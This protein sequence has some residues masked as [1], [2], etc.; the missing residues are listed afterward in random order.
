MMIGILYQI[1][2]IGTLGEPLIAVSAIDLNLIFCVLVSRKVTQNKNAAVY[3]L[4]APECT[5]AKLKRIPCFT[6]GKTNDKTPI[7]KR[8]S[9]DKFKSLEQ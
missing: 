1:A 8:Q 4:I 3:F 6:R 9:N 2:P 5:L 7:Y